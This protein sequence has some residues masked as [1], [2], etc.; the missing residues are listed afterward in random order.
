MAH[1]HDSK[2]APPNKPLPAA[3]QRTWHVNLQVMSGDDEGLLQWLVGGPGWV[4]FIFGWCN[5]DLMTES[6]LSC[7]CWKFGCP[8][9]IGDD[10]D[11]HGN[12]MKLGSNGRVPFSTVIE[13]HGCQ[14]GRW[15][16]PNPPVGRAKLPLKRSKNSLPWTLNE[17]NNGQ[18]RLWHVMACFSWGAIR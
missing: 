1:P 4:V 6:C 17:K 18:N 5:G 16:A 3:R 8:E 7:A 9:R 15:S 2:V 11:M 14:G 10:R 13:W 12:L